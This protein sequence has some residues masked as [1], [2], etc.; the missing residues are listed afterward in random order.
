[1]T[2]SR[3]ITTHP[4]TRLCNQLRN[5]LIL[6]IC[7]LPTTVSTAFSSEQKVSTD[8]FEAPQYQIHHASGS[9]IIDGRLDEADWF[10]APS[11]GDFHFT[12]Y[13]EGRQEQTVAKMLW[14]EENLYVAHVC[15]DSGITAQHAD[16]DGRIPEDDCFEVIF[17]PNP[18]QPEVYFNIEWN[19]IGGYVDN[20]RPNGPSKPRA[21]VWDAKGVRIAGNSIGTVNDDSDE[22]GCWVVEVAIPLENF[23]SSMKHFPI[24]A[25]DSWNLNLNRHGGKRDPQYSQWSPADTVAP[26]FHTPHRFGKV[27]F[28]DRRLP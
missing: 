24:K 6:T 4:A 11:V 27:F 19:V 7:S 17:A 9:I 13:K 26:N 15:R 20:H 12:W 25:G 21:P 10:T 22:D 14:D 2:T 28:T 8:G 23:R 5:F 16:H 3:L 1:M 18:D